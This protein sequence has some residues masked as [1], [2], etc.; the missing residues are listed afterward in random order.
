MNILVVSDIYRN[1]A[2]PTLAPGTA[3]SEQEEVLTTLW[4]AA[5]ASDPAVRETAR[6]F[7]AAFWV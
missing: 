7:L 2:A 6:A 1:A 3:G 4:E 5:R